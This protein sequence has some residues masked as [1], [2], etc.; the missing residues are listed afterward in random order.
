MVGWQRPKIHGWRR[1]RSF[2]QQA[3]ASSCNSHIQQHFVASFFF[4]VSLLFVFSGIGADSGSLILL[5]LLFWELR[6]GIWHGL[7]FNT[8]WFSAACAFC[9][10]MFVSSV[11]FIF[12]EGRLLRWL[13]CRSDSY[14]VNG[15]LP[16]FICSSLF[17]RVLRQRTVNGSSCGTPTSA[18]SHSYCACQ[19]VSATLD[20]N[21]VR[22]E[23]ES[24]WR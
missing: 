4:L 7:V 13:P 20:N 9:V 21:C 3:L 10:R 11:V 17:I 18:D 23:N 14:N 1:M 8:G 22:E 16:K 19:P 15:Y 24:R 6:M 5:V 12:E 2:F